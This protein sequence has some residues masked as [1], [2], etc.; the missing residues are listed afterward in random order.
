MK[1]SFLFLIVFL[2]CGILSAQELEGSWKLISKNGEPVTNREVIRIIQDGYFAFGAK[3]I[4]S[5]NFINAAGGEFVL[6]GSKYIEIRDFD[7]ADPNIVGKEQQ[8]ELKWDGQDKA[9]IS[10]GGSTEVWQRISDKKDELTGNW[11]ITGRERNG[12]MITMTPGNRRTVKI[13]SGGR[14]QWIAFNSASKEFSGTGGGTYTAEDGKYIENIEFF[15][16]ENRRVGAS[17]EFQYEVKDGKW[18]H[19]GASSKGDPIYEI[20]SPYKEAYKK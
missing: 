16:R 12:E 14:F 2:F 7:T 20:W 9:I 13:L 4:G 3:E 15:S 5:N 19:K 17:L 10:N 1:N 8:F 11:V 6:E 18:H